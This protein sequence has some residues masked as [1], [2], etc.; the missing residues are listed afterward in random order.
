MHIE[1]KRRGIGQFPILSIEPYF[2]ATKHTTVVL[3]RRDWNRQSQMSSELHEVG[4]NL[5]CALE[6]CKIAAGC[7]YQA[8]SEWLKALFFFLQYN[9][10]DSRGIGY[11]R[12]PVTYNR[13]DLTI[14]QDWFSGF[15]DMSFKILNGYDK[16]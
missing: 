4:H 3:K 15:D 7:I 13:K 8:Y 6:L 12:N 1:D 5:L 16:N 9:Y 14:C 2:Y 10:L 11:R